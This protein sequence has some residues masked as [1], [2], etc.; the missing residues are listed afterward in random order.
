MQNQIIFPFFPIKLGHFKENTIV[1]ICYKQSSLTARIRKHSL[2][3]R[4][5][6]PKLFPIFSDEKLVNRKNIFL[7]SSSSRSKQN[8]CKQQNEMNLNSRLDRALDDDDDD[9]NLINRQRHKT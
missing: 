7:K 5:S 9:F 2:D 4:S 1:F 6:L 8:K 3:S